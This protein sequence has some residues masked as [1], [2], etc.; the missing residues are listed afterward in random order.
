MQASPRSQDLGGLRVGQLV[1]HAKFGQGVI[2]AAEGSGADARVQINF[3]SAGIKW[4]MLAVAKLSP[5]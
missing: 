3:G 5:A 1:T 4:L 2:V